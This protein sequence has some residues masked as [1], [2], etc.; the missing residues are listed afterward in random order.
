MTEKICNSKKKWKLFYCA[1]IA[2]PV[3]QFLIFYIGVNFNSLILSFEK[4]S[5][6]EGRYFFAGFD[7]FRKVFSDIVGVNYMRTAIYNSIIGCLCTILIGSTFALFF[8]F[9]MYKKAILHGVFKVVLFMPSIISSVALVLIFKYFMEVGYP[10]LVKIL[11]GTPGQ[12]LLYGKNAFPVILFYNIWAGFG[13]QIVMFSGAMNNVS[14]DMVEAAQI[15]G[16]TPFKEFYYITLP[17]IYPTVVVFVAVGL[18]GLFTN[19]LNLFNFFGEDAEYSVYSVG[20]YLYK[21]IVSTDVTIEQYP[22]LSAYGIIL[23]VVS[24]PLA[25]GAKKALERFGPKTE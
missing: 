16:I 6:E 12:S 4:Y 11:T 3:L 15:D 13:V 17:S 24:V 19:Q 14:E 22:Y 8:S 2:F 5:Y 18:A 21:N 10:E 25:L 7:N 20:Y 9:Y 1:W 23:T